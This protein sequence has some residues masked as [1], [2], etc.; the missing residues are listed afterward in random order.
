MGG[1]KSKNPVETFS[2]P[3]D[4][5]E[6][7]DKDSEIK[8]DIFVGNTPT[9]ESKKEIDE[10]MD[11]FKADRELILKK[12]YGIVD[13]DTYLI[14]DKALLVGSPSDILKYLYGKI[15][16]DAYQKVLMYL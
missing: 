5:L 8:F 16:F 11:H 9:E 15:S 2:A 14:I 10:V 4:I 3:D 6:S 12:V 13:F 7:P 1:N